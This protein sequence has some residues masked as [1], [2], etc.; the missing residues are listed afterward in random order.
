MSFHTV[1]LFVLRIYVR[2]FRIN[3]WSMKWYHQ[4]PII[5]LILRI[6]SRDTL[7]LTPQFFIVISLIEWE[8]HKN[9]E[10]VCGKLRVVILATIKIN[11]VTND[12]TIKGIPTNISYVIIPTIPDNLITATITPKPVH[13][14]IAW[15]S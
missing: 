9:I 8:A 11:A 7:N 13:L 4:F 6:L 10:C 3:Q 15:I 1:L 12:G 14:S 5:S 2:W